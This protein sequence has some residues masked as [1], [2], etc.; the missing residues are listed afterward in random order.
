ML[1]VKSYSKDYI[2]ACRARTDAQLAAHA[3]LGAAAGKGKA[4]SAL[5]AFEAPFFNDLTLVLE[6]YFVRRTR[7]IEGKDGNPLNE[8]R[9]ICVSL[10]TTT[11]CS[12]RTRPSSTSR[13]LRC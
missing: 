12:R 13:R 3:A 5:V 2:K 10:L 1:A 6:S 8:V 11:A 4:R 9:M 7:A